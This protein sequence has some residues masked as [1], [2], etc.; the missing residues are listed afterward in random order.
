MVN[1]TE[2][3][4]KNATEVDNIP[5]AIGQNEHWWIDYNSLPVGN[6]KLIEFILDPKSINENPPILRDGEGYKNNDRMIYMS[7]SPKQLLDVIVESKVLEKY[8]EGRKKKLDEYEEEFHTAC[9]EFRNCK[10]L[11]RFVDKHELKLEE[12]KEWDKLKPAQK[13]N[14]ITEAIKGKYKGIPSER[15]DGILKD[16]E[17][18]ESQLDFIR[19]LNLELK[20]LKAWNKLEH[21]EKPNKIIAAIENKYMDQCLDFV[22]GDDSRE[23]NAKERQDNK[24][25]TL[26][27]YNIDAFKNKALRFIDIEN[28]QI[29]S[30]LN[31][32]FQPKREK[33]EE[34]WKRGKPK[35]KGW[36]T[37]KSAGWERG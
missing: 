35:E 24:N 4:P 11:E 10:N 15:Y 37:E 8:T 32:A 13:M 5:P 25:S 14:K 22:Y 20:E 36:K 19:K 3:A 34:G 27:E 23:K 29:L 6:K 30:Q 1:A 26:A 2:N 21:N 18:S 7:Y 31:N 17:G 16:L 9:K 33:P 12:L 28:Y